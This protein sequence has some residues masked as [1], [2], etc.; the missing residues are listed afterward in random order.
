MSI[1]DGTTSELRCGIHDFTT[2]NLDDWHKH[3]KG[4]GHY[5]VGSGNCAVCGEEYAFTLEDK[6]PTSQ[7]MRGVIVHPECMGGK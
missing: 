3:L 4:E 1:V 5:S 2:T 6:V 7:V